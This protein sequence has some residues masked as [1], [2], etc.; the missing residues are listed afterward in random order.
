MLLFKLLSVQYLQILLKGVMPM[1]PVSKPIFSY[2]PSKVNFPYGAS[3]LAQDPALSVFNVAEYSLAVNFFVNS[4]KS[5]SVGLLEKLKGCIS[6]FSPDLIVA[7]MYC[8]G[9]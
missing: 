6:S 1:P 5:F 2:S 8:P 4:T 3:I 9:L 7:N